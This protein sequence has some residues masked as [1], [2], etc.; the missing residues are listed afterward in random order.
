MT[1]R[2]YTSLVQSDLY[3]YCANKAMGEFLKHLITHPGLKYLFVMRSVKYLKGK[4]IFGFPVYIIARLVL[5][6]YGYKYGISIP[7]NTKT[8]KG[9]YIGHFGGIVVHYE[10]IIGDNC[11]IN[12][13]VTIGATYGGKYP[14]TPVIGN[15]V[16]MGPGSKIIGGITVGNNV[17]VGANCVVSKP[18]PNNAVVVG[19]PGE[20]IS[21][22]GAANYVINIA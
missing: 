12:H 13:E 9:L 11:N 22:D 19:V 18:I 3:R 2:E 10:A 6:H 8:G 1:F 5:R 4:G 20:I 16:Y 21:L 15:N 7:Y 17:A 14:G